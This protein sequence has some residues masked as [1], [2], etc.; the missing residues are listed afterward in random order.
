MKDDPSEKLTTAQLS[1]D[2]K[3]S[4]NLEVVFAPDEVE[5]RRLVQLHK[6]KQERFCQNKFEHFAERFN[7]RWKNCGI[8]EEL[9]EIIGEE[10]ICK[11]LWAALG[12]VVKSWLS[13]PLPALRGQTALQCLR[14]LQGREA[15]KS[16][17]L[18]LNDQADNLHEITNSSG[19]FED[20]EESL[21]EL[22]LHMPKEFDTA[23]F[24]KFSTCC[25]N[26]HFYASER[27]MVSQGEGLPYLPLFVH[28]PADEPQARR[29]LI[30]E[31]MH[32]P[33]TNGLGIVIM[34]PHD[35]TWGWSYGA[36]SFYRKHGTFFD[37][38]YGD[39][40]RLAATR[41]ASQQTYLGA[42]DENVLPSF[43]RPVL[44]KVLENSLHIERPAV[45]VELNPSREVCTRIIFNILDRSWDSEQEVRQA[46][47][48]LGWFILPSCIVGTTSSK[49]SKDYLVT[50]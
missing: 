3:A 21:E 43:M 2:L 17:L 18:G 49:E 42:P 23:W 40:F 33:T 15:M 34:A 10:A 32:Q 41:L 48:F 19:V 28:A 39:A 30:R 7:A 50:L 22:F 24:S 12:S 9:K 37:P 45:M 35:R 31:I 29:V 8:Q 44:K 1:D 38:K 16:L 14:S 20:K 47:D 27:S 36:V 26:A 6:K 25:A 46:V 4:D 13:D 11:V 5:Q